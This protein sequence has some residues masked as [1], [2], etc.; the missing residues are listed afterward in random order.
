MPNNDDLLEY[1]EIKTKIIII[2]SL[3]Y[4]GIYFVSFLFMYCYLK[5]TNYIKSKS[6]FLLLI[7]ALTSLIKLFLNND[8]FFKIL[9]IFISN[10][11]QFHLIISSINDLLSGKDLFNNKNNF[12]I[13]KIILIEVFLFPIIVF[14][15]S[16]FFK[17]YNILIDICQSLIIILSIIKFYYYVERHI[18]IIFYNLSGKNK[19]KIILSYF[20]SD[21]LLR[22]YE[23]LYNLWKLIYFLCLFYY[24]IKLIDIL[25]LKTFLFI[26]FILDLI[27]ICI[28][29]ST[30]FVVFFSLTYINC[31]LNNI[32]NKKDNTIQ[33][34]D[35]ENNNEEDDLKQE[36]KKTKNKDKDEKKKIRK[37]SKKNKDKYKNLKNDQYEEDNVIEI[38]NKDN[39]ND[40][41]EN[42]SNNEE[43]ILDKEDESKSLSVK[44]KKKKINK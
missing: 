36:K 28:E 5:K 27:L 1:N 37:K 43:E 44:K 34:E 32:Y 14:P 6:Y 11:V 40:K 33:I 31:L 23:I 19:D 30:V 38:Y 42:D 9:F 39:S 10:I 13:K 8:S 16:Y 26:D 20:E 7:S 35:Y 21:K 15:Y 3:I 24:I 25:F 2:F 17:S 41:E 22:I 12:S 4:L 29:A 18:S